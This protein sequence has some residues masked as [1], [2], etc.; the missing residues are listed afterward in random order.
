MRFLCDAMLGRLA[1][2]LRAA[3]HDTRLAGGAER[4]G[5]LLEAAAR[6]DRILLT[7]DRGLAG[8]RAG[9]GRVLL[10][11]SERIE[12][13]AREL[14]RRLAVD[15]LHAPF[16]RCVV[17]NALLRPAN[18]EEVATLPRKLRAIGGPVARCPLCQRLYWAGDH[19][20]RM[21]ERLER[22]QAEGAE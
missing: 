6:E 3:G 13:Q 4:D 8:R 14:R 10:L 9:Q 7:L 20:H 5:D 15:W 17:D 21:R 2:W 19:H 22:W 12:A 18:A 11:G 1:R 16:T